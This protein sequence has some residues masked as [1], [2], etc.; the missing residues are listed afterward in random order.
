MDYTV[1]QPFPSGLGNAWRLFPVDSDPRIAGAAMHAPGRV[2]Q[3]GCVGDAEVPFYAEGSPRQGVKRVAL[4]RSDT[5][6]VLDL[7]VED[8]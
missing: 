6:N 7:R 5:K 4:R 1:V 2:L 3:D 8:I